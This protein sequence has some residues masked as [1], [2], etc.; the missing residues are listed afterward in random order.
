[1]SQQLLDTST[2]NKRIAKNTLIL[3][4]RMLLM[5]VISLY[6]SRVVLN[7]L[8]IE[9][10]GIYN[11]VGGVVSMFTI[12]SGSLTAAI[13]RFITIE[14]GKGNKV[15]LN[16]VFCSAVNVQIALIIIVFILL[17]TIGFWFLNYKMVIPQ[18]RIVAANWVFQFSVITFA[19]GLWCV[20][21][22]ALIVAHEKMSA[23]AYISLFEAFAKLLIAFAIWANPIDRLIYF[24][25][26]TLSVGLIQ[27]F[28]NTWYC[29]KHFEE[30][31]YKFMF[32]AAVTKEMF[33][34]AGWN[35][36]GSSSA[37]LRDAGGNMIINLFFGPTVNAAR[38][39]AMS[40]NGTITGFVANFMTA[41]NP[42]ITK[43]YASGNSEYMFKLIF[44]GARLSYYILL[45]LAL[46]ILFTTQYLLEIWLGIVPQHAANF[47]RLVLIFAMSESLANPLVT[48]MLATGKIRNYQL[49][50]GGC[51]LLN[52][53]VSYMLLR[54]GFPPESIFIVAIAVS[55]LCEM[56][57]LIMLKGMINLSVRAFLKNVY[58]NVIFV[59]VVAAVLPFVI[60]GAI[61]LDCF[62]DFVII[63]AI[64]VI[65]AVVSIYLIGCNKHDRELIHKGI[66][67]VI[68]RMK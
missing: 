66:N 40:V 18:D 31:N 53:P 28:I 38:G 56:T 58:F 51:Q 19:V 67:K 65:S 45:V 42:Q 33:S 1:M 5:M 62:T 68:K 35:F 2:N 29:K 54:F 26:L 7:A 30:C 39:V 61:G 17:E 52:L 3:Y 50:V 64:S 15:K 9:D 41:L 59:T 4:A 36:I 13:G 24:G 14:I 11:V 16:K 25:I 46:P 44:Q 47:A 10:Y 34:F 55:V 48:V 37:I 57:R 20:P 8:G 43:N 63:C 23:F 32:D 49:I 60:K 21:Y 12:L 6:T 22:N 27:R